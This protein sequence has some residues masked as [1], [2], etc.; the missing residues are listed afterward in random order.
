MVA[1]IFG[2]QRS[3]R[4]ALIINRFIAGAVD[5]HPYLPSSEPNISEKFSREAAMRLGIDFIPPRR[6]LLWQRRIVEPVKEIQLLTLTKCR[7]R[8]M[9]D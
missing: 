7:T 4:V 1:V 5:S 8:V 6:V 3:A 9:K 2:S